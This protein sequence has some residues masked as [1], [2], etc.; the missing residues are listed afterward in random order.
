MLK[1]EQILLGGNP[2]C[3]PGSAYRYTSFSKEALTVIYS[4]APQDPRDVVHGAF[5][6]GCRSRGLLIR[7]SPRLLSRS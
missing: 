2:C 5:P 1:L 7:P 6:S 4:L 3:L